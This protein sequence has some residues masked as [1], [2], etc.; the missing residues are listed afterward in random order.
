MVISPALTSHRWEH[1]GDYL[2]R[3][4]Q[5]VVRRVEGMR[6]N[7]F[8][9]LPTRA[10]PHVGVPARSQR[11]ADCEIAEFGLSIYSFPTAREASWGSPGVV[12]IQL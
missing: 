5:G 8:P 10:F 9:R 2:R 6:F 11:S 7:T 12:G 1:R 3:I 4:A